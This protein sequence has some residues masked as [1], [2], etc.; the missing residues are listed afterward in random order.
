MGA[1]HDWIRSRR[2][3]EVATLLTGVG[4]VLLIVGLATA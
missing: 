4:C 1:L 2:R 3:M